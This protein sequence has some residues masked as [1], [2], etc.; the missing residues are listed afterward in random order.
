M[1]HTIIDAKNAL[2]DAASTYYQDLSELSDYNSIWL[3][4]AYRDAVR[5]GEEVAKQF[6]AM[7]Q[8][9][10]NEIA[11]CD[12]DVIHYLADEA[13]SRTPHNVTGASPYEVI[14][15]AAHL[16]IFELKTV[17]VPVTLLSEIIELANHQIYRPMVAEL[18]NRVEDTINAANAILKNNEVA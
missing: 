16:K 7:S 5:D 2:Q 4:N 9:E 10:K 6:M 12:D 1:I 18:R 15:A 13:A 3:D 14:K 17:P 11:D 8:S